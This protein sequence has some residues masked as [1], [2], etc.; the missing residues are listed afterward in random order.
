MPRSSPPIL[1][2]DDGTGEDL[3]D[4]LSRWTYFNALVAVVRCLKGGNE[5]FCK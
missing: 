2:I 4:G 3:F 5:G 1:S